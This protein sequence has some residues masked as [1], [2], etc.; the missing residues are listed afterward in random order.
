MSKTRIFALAV[1]ILMVLA[2][3]TNPTKEQHE[4]AVRAKAIVLLKEQAGSENQSIVDFGVQLFGNTLI[5]QFMKNHIKTDNYFLFSVTKVHWDNQETI[6][7]VGAFQHV[8][9]SK[10]IDEKAAAIVDMIKA[11]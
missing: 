3:W 2:F 8:W 5:D 10:K 7:G 11:R 6:L 1:I 9:L 4:D